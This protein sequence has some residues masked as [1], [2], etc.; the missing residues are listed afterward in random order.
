MST[1]I[2][3]RDELLAQARGLAAKADSQGRDFTPDE[4][5]EAN[6]LLDGAAAGVRELPDRYRPP[7]D[8]VMQEA[9]YT[10]TGVVLNPADDQA[11]DLATDAQQR[12]YG[13]GPFRRSRP[14]A[15]LGNTQGAVDAD[16][17]RSGTHR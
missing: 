17:C 15:D 12:Y 6:R 9:G 5:A 4:L 1:L 14:R 16:A 2:E 10:V 7:R 13:S 11:L 3:Q 8:G